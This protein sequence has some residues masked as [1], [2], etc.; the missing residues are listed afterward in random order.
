M[1]YA[2]RFLL[3]LGITWLVEIPVL[4]ALIRVVLKR[5][6][7]TTSGIIVAGILATGLTLPC[8]WFILPQ[9]ISAAYYLPVGELFVVITECLILCLVLRTRPVISF[10]L[11]VAM[12]AAS[13]V[14]GWL[15]LGG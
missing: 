5:S 7:I 2:A 12:N 10:A 3:A 4:W 14:A 8:L 1:L 9:Y 6:D 15:L 11:S 13:F